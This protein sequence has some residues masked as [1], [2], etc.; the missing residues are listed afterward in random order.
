YYLKW[1][2]NVQES[3]G[4]GVFALPHIIPADMLADLAAE[5]AVVVPHMMASICGMPTYREHNMLDA[6]VRRAN[7]LVIDQ[8][9]QASV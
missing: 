9:L 1:M 5:N 6:L 4:L 7:A 8:Y 3:R 2:P